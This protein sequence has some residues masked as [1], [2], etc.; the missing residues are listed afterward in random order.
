MPRSVT[1]NKSRFQQ[2]GFTLV[3][4]LIAIAI[5]GFVLGTA[6]LQVTNLFKG[7]QSNASVLNVNT[8][9]ANELEN[10][11]ENWSEV[12]NWES[13]TYVSS[14]SSVAFS[15]A[16]W[17]NIKV[18]PTSFGSSC[19]GNSYLKRVKLAVVGSDNKKLTVFLDVARP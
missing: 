11:K 2:S 16:N 10:L 9:A 18:A 13:G 12:S 19:S 7:N 15:C 14:N 5:L 6:V 1:F 8:L 3:E 4:I 17:T